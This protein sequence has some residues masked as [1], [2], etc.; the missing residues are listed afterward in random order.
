MS[1]KYKRKGN[2]DVT[3]DG[4]TMFVEDIVRDLDRKSFLE[5]ELEAKDKEN[6]RLRWML[7]VNS[8]EQ[9]YLDDGEMQDNSKLPYIDYKRDLIGEIKEKLSM[10]VLGLTKE[11][12]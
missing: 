5:V 2:Y 6:Q 3:K 10:R 12:E 4:H 9:P 8:C 11:G 1:Y 7:C